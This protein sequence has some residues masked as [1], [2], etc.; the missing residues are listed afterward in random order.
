MANAIYNNYKGKIGT[1]D[2]NDNSGV[3]VKVMLV[4]SSYTVDVDAHL[5]KK[6]IDDLSV[7]ASGDGYTAGGAVV[8][9]RVIN[10]DNGTDSAKF[11]ADDVTWTNSTITAHG[12]VIYQDTGDNTTSTLIAYV[13]F[14]ADKS[15]SDGDFVLQWAT[16]GV[17]KIA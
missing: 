7:E 11:D 15:S 9:N 1:I 16:D 17:Y 3:T 5:V 14:G 2:W 8:A 4:T 6:D 10:I 13:D 12:A